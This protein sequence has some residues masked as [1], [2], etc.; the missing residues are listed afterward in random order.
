ME[1]EFNLSKLRDS[2]Y[3]QLRQL[4]PEL[5]AEFF[6]NLIKDQDKEFIKILK[7]EK[8]EYYHLNDEN[9]I[10]Y[11]WRHCESNTKSLVKEI[12]N[13]IIHRMNEKRDNLAGNKLTGVPSDGTK[14]DKLTW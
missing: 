8:A 13:L 7:E 10:L 14:G 2:L 9:H 3:Y 5:N 4:C 12:Y 6:I 1:K 11:P